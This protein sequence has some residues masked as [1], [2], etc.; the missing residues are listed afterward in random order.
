MVARI[1]RSLKRFWRLFWTAGQVDEP[2]VEVV[3]AAAVDPQIKE[4][5]YMIL[6]MEHGQRRS[7]VRSL[8][9]RLTAQNAPNGLISALA[10]LED[11]SF[12]EATLKVLEI[13]L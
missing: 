5:L 10:D 11:D 8:V 13:D 12:A 7:A 2:L 9:A 6:R 3:R 1:K 4:S